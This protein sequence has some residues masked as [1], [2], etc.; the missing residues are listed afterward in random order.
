VSFE[1][2][3]TVLITG[4]WS[5]VAR[6][7]VVVCESWTAIMVPDDLRSVVLPTRLLLKRAV[8]DCGSQAIHDMQHSSQEVW[9]VIA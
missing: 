1:A 9:G 6:A 4:F 5:A 2:A 3:G 7:V 8:R